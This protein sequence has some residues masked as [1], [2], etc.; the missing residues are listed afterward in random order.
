MILEL[1]GMSRD[2]R[3]MTMA[4]ALHYHAI[5]YYNGAADPLYARAC[6]LTSERGPYRLRLSDEDFE[7]R[8][9]C[10]ETPRMIVARLCERYNDPAPS[11]TWIETGEDEDGAED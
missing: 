7:L 4:I 1:Q 6:Q 8:G 5:H 2:E 3:R 9:E 10:N 11:E